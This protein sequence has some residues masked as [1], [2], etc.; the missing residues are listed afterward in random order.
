MKT[1]LP[2]ALFMLLM[3]TAVANAERRRDPLTEAEVDQLREARM[4]PYNRLKLFTKFA[5]A[6]LDSIDRLQSDPAQAAGRGKLIHDLLQDFT[7]IVDEL[8]SNMD[9]YAGEA[10]DKDQQKQFHK[11]LKEVIL[12]TDRMNGRLRALMK[13]ASGDP[14][15]RSEAQDYVFALHDAQ[16]TLKSALD[17]AREYAETMTEQ[18]KNAPAEKKR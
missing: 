16:E 13:S 2:V 8:N 15:T 11:G 3:T 12:G 6:R 7:T 18:K 10:M 5:E 9:N 14:N 17:I 1:F 4:E